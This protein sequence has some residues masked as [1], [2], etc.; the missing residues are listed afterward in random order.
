MVFYHIIKS[1]KYNILLLALLLT[2]CVS[3]KKLTYLKSQKELIETIPSEDYLLSAQD[4]LYVSI[5]TSSEEVN[6]YFGISNSQK[7]TNY[8]SLEQS[9]S[10]YLKSYSVNDSGY[11]KLPIIGEVLV[12]GKTLKVAE[13][14]I[15]QKLDTY[16]QNENQVVLK[17]ANNTFT[18]LGEVN[19]QGKYYLHQNQINI[20][21]AIGMGMGLTEYANPETIKIV[22]KYEG[23]TKTYQ[24]NL[25]TQNPTDFIVFPNDVIYIS[26]LKKG[27][28]IQLKSP[29]LPVVLSGFSSV[30]IMISLL[31][32]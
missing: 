21:E 14:E 1:Y 6:T 31:V 27:A 12:G 20:L 23:K 16:F 8:Q 11:V 7:L 22:R 24:I 28:Q 26:P 17:L 9:P 5:H 2:S 15:Q 30:L 3:N 25:N 32:K 29:T 4:L 13:A 18:V 10:L 19:K